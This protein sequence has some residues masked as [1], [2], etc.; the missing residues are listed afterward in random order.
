MTT[1]EKINFLMQNHEKDGVSEISKNDAENNKSATSEVISLLEDNDS[2]FDG[3]KTPDQ[4]QRS[5]AH[6][7]SPND[8]PSKPSVFKTPENLEKQTS[9]NKIFKKDEHAIVMAWRSRTSSPC[10][11]SNSV[12]SS[13][14]S[15]GSNLSFKEKKQ[16]LV[17]GAV[18]HPSV[19]AMKRLS[20][21][22]NSLANSAISD[23]SSKASAV[24]SFASFNFTNQ[25]EVQRSSSGVQ[26]RKIQPSPTPQFVQPMAPT[27][28]ST[29]E[30]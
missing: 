28:A 21:M 30:S 25:P 10:P 18:K 3:P 24:D 23:I 11:S 13:Q 19:F 1:Q 12:K 14:F 8:F 5:K 27:A 6:Y 9:P 15:I 26:F 17:Q 16:I 22:S 4:I 20:S 7:K 2:I 29:L